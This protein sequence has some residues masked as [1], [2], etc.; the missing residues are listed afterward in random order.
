VYRKLSLAALLLALLALLASCGAAPVAEGQ[1]GTVSEPRPNQ[2]SGL[3]QDLLKQVDAAI[4]KQKAA[5]ADVTAAQALRDSAVQLD[6]QGHAEEANG[7]LK[8]AAGMVGVLRSAGNAP[9]ASGALPAV[10][11]APAAQPAVA[12]AQGGTAL[13]PKFDSADALKSWERIGPSST[14][15]TPLWDVSNGMLL[16]RGLDGVQ[17][18]DDPTALVTGDPAWHDV[19]IR[20]A[21][22][23]QGNKE[24]GLIARQNGNSFYRFRV[25]ALGTGTN[26]GNLILEKV[27]DGQASQIAAFDGPELSADV[28]HTL[29]LSVRG[30]MITCSVDG[31]QVGTAEDSSLA[32]GRAG[33]T[34]LAMSTTYF[35]NV[36]VIG[37]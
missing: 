22:L 13:N 29:G 25:L 35:A 15:G 30:T 19:T 17:S 28:W 34:T 9:A 4:A 33:V 20:A 32:S 14:F 8:T 36:Q 11:A 6:Q 3:D 18:S 21:V 12:D 26:S 31:K 1:V 10:P 37:R 16:Q 24:A 27:V 23:V 2:A 7:N 5:G